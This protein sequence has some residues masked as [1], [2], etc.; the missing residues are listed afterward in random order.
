MCE[1]MDSDFD[2]F[3]YYT[4]VRWMSKCRVLKREYSLKDEIIIC[5]QEQ[6][7]IKLTMKWEVHKGI[8]L[9]LQMN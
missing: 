6:H 5:L 3:L 2:N 9:I 4:Q 1:E 7:I 8:K